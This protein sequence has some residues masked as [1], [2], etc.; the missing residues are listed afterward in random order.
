MYASN[1]NVLTRG[2]LLSTKDDES[3][4]S[5]WEPIWIKPYKVDKEK[6]VDSNVDYLN[7]FSLVAISGARIMASDGD[8][9]LFF[10][11]L[12]NFPSQVWILR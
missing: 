10:K 12:V 2:L 3:V 4:K 9:Y 8:F 6:G 5:R 11:Y 7:V 1:N